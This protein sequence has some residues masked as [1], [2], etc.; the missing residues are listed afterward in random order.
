MY[1][2]T[3]ITSILQYADISM[4][5]GADEYEI[6]KYY[7]WI[8]ETDRLEM[9]DIV[10]D[11]IRY[12]QPYLGGTS[13]FD[14]LVNYLYALI[15]KWIASAEVISNNPHGIISGQPIAP[16]NPSTG[17]GQVQV[18]VGG[19]GSPIPANSY[20]Y[21][22]TAFIGKTIIVIVDG[23]IIQQNLPL[24]FSYTFN[25]TTGT[26]LFNSPLNQNQVVTVVYFG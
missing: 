4:F 2:S 12:Y 25:S 5:L 21:T 17:I 22:S 9:I 13:Q 10:K 6:E 15:G 1:N 20:S 8:D 24:Q 19:T 26:I 14:R 7:N 11:V 23:I 18:I 16:V 3:T